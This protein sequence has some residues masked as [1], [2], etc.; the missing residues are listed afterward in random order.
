MKNYFKGV[1]I[2]SVIIGFAI[3]LIWLLSCYA[4]NLLKNEIVKVVIIFG[5]AFIM[6][7]ALSK[8]NKKYD[9]NNPSLDKDGNRGE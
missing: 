8:V 5:G 3:L 1:L 4:P 2:R 9:L 6:S 7:N